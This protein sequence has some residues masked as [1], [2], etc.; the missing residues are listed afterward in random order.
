MTEV[1]NDE[2]AALQEPVQEIVGLT[3]EP[4][5]EPLLPVDDDMGFLDEA[6]T[7]GTQQ[8]NSGALY[9]NK[10][11]RKETHPNSKGRALVGGVWYWVSGW[12]NLMPGGTGRY[13]STSYTPMTPEDIVKYV[14]NK[15]VRPATP[16]SA[17]VYGAEV[18]DPDEPF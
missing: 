14:E 13:I 17:S 4:T 10:Q 6:P 16:T 8:N 1:T 11:R 2:K 15:P 5:Q 12:N 7:Q 9:P 3:Q 18:A